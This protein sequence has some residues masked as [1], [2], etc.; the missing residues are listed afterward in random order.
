MKIIDA[1]SHIFPEKI[2]K[3]AV[4]SIGD[5]YGMDNMS[6]SGSSE[7]LKKS[8]SAIGVEKYLVFSTATTPKQVQ[9]INRFINSEC[10]K[11]SEFI[12]LGTMHIGYE[13]FEEEIK[14]LK[15]VGIRGIKLHP[16]FQE[17]AFNDEKMMPI[18][19]CLNAEKMFVLTHSGD[20]RYSFSN[21]EKVCDVAKKFPDLNIIAAHFGGWSEWESARDLLNLPNVYF[22]TSSTLGFEGKKYA[23]EILNK[24]DKTHFFFGTDFPMWDHEKEL[25]R[26]LSLKLSDKDTEDILYNNFKN[27]Y[28]L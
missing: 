23:I 19:E 9:R 7:E 1:H 20:K 17:F 24:F 10:E 16:D 22:D 18:Y 3:K 2:E 13:D 5:F 28:E 14:F 25:S 26:F 21:P 4:K 15:S 27:F 8:G 6:H 12:G 11:H